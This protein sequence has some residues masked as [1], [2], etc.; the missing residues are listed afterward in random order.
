MPVSLQEAIDSLYQIAITDK[1]STSTLRLKRLA[2]Y[3]AEQLQLR[4]L[5][6]AKPECSIPGAGRKKAWDVGWEYDGKYRL[7][8]SL[9]SLLK[10]LSGTV[11]NRID[12]LMGE[13]ANVQLLSPEIVCGY[14]MIFDVG[15]DA[16]SSKHGATWAQFLR[17]TLTSLSQRRPP[18]WTIGT[19]EAVVLAEVNFSLSPQ[20]L[21]GADLLPVFFDTLVEQVRFRNPNAIPGLPISADAGPKPLPE[22]LSE[23]PDAS[24]QPLR[25]QRRT[26]Q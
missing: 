7:A 22:E 24:S 2:E 11:P 18:T 17:T 23:P 26:R 10:N 4:G 6:G 3:C 25:I 5:T 19:V 20:L 16:H 8:I 14:V 13:A 21:S 1:K 9:K 15:A 12:D